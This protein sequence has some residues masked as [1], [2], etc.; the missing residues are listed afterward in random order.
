MKI[1]NAATMFSLLYSE[2]QSLL[3]ISFLNYAMFLLLC[4]LFMISALGF[5]G[6]ILFLMVNI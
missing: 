5:G 3:L 1:V 2:P 6:S 4:F